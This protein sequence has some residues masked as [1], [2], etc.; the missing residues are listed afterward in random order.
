MARKSRRKAKKDNKVKHQNSDKRVQV[1]EVVNKLKA[2]S[3]N[4]PSGLEN[5]GNTC[6]F[7]SALQSLAQTKLLSSLLAARSGDDCVWDARTV[8]KT[9]DPSSRCYTSESAQIKLRP[10]S[11]FVSIFLDLLN[12]ISYG[13]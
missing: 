7:N 13:R 10:P 5:L 3:L 4:R 12:D 6:F 9:N 8:F 11:K 2:L 1:L